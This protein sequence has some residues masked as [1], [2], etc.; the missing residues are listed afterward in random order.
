M[1]P[2]IV[3]RFLIDP[4]TT[5]NVIY[6]DSLTIIS[7]DTGRKLN[8]HK[9]FRRRPALLLNVICTFIVRPVSR[10][11]ELVTELIFQEI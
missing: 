7:L 9:T 2:S 5:N 10:G 8:V 4:L 6:R 11:M 3:R 1:T